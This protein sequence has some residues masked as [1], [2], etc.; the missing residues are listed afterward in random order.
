MKNIRP[1]FSYFGSKY[2]LSRKLLC[3]IPP[4]HTYI[5]PY[6]GSAAMFFAKQP[7]K[8]EILNDIN[9]NIFTLFSILRDPLKLETL[10]RLIS[11]TPYSREE[12]ESAQNC[13]HE[14]DDI[15]RTWKFLIISNMGFASRQRYKTGWKTGY[16]NYRT[17]SV[18][19]RIPERLAIAALRLKNAQIDNRPGID[20][21]ARA[22]HKESFFFIDPPYPYYS[23]NTPK[24]CYDFTMSD[25]DHYDLVNILKTITGS[26]M[27]TM[28]Q[29]K[30]YDQL[31]DFGY[32]KIIVVNKNLHKNDK[33]ETIYMNYQYTGDLFSIPA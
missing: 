21:I 26:A 1:V 2:F 7:S 19:N 22:D 28:Y 29:N 24:H 31:I 30:V 25:D 17:I 3:L 23:F 16:K 15:V 27:I 8:V 32:H 6:C 14:D 13:K 10:S 12:Y 11:F 33:T 18:W 9:H 4:H 20:V 5:E